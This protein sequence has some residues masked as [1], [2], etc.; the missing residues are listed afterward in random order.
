MC[1]SIQGYLALCGCG[2]FC[3]IDG[4]GGGGVG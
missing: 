1:Q 3:S 2:D 4:G